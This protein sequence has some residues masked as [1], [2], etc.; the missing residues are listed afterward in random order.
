MTAHIKRF[1][2]GFMVILT[3]NIGEILDRIYVTEVQ[4]HEDV[5]K[6]I[7]QGIERDCQAV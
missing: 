4:M 1:G 5:L 7:L 3:N 6:T 2:D